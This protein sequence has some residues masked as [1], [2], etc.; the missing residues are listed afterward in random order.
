[1]QTQTLGQKSEAALAWKHFNIRTFST[2]GRDVLGHKSA[3]VLFRMRDAR[4]PKITHL[5]QCTHIT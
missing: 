4:E 2:P 3:V 5:E 1:M